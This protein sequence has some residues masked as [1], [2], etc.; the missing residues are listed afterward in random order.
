MPANASIPPQSGRL[1]TPLEMSL[2]GA[3]PEAGVSRLGFRFAPKPAIRR[4][5]AESRILL[6]GLKTIDYDPVSDTV[7]SSSFTPDR[8]P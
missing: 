8:G 3:K 1:A 5:Y 7:S 4:V 6:L 2:K